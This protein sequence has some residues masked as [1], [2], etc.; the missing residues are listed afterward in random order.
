MFQIS[1]PPDLRRNFMQISLELHVLFSI[2]EANRL[3]VSHKFR[4]KCV[5]F[6]KAQADMVNTVCKCINPFPN[7]KF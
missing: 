1:S 7:D 3:C 5:G 4:C 6:K 2:T